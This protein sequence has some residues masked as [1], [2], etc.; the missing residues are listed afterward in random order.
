[1]VLL[2]GCG[3]AAEDYY[4]MPMKPDPAIV[5]DGDLSDWDLVPNPIVLKGREHVTYSPELWD[6]DADLSATVRLCWRTGLLAIAAEV[7]DA[8]LRQPYAGA[9][10]WR[11]DH[12]N[13]WVDFQPGVDPERT[14]FGEG[15]VHLVV[16]PGD[17]GAVKPEIH[18][19]R[20]E[21]RNPG[22]GEAAARRT[23]T[24][25]IVEAVI[26]VERLGVAALSMYKD[27]NFEVALSDADNE[28]V[29]QESLMTRGTEPWVYSRKRVLPMVF[30]DG[31][32]KAPPPLR[33]TLLKDHAEIAAGQTLTLPFDSGAIPEGKEA[34]VFLRARYPQEKVTGFRAEALH[35]DLNGKRVGVDR[36]ANRA[37]RMTLMRGTDE[38]MVSAD[39][40][41]ALYYAPDYFPSPERHALYG[42]IDGSNPTEYEFRLDGVLR[43]GS[44]TLTVSN[45][46][47]VTPEHAHTAH[48]DSVEFR[49]RSK[50]APP[51]P[52][53]PAPTG[54]IPWIAPATTFPKSY[55]ATPQPGARIELT[56]AGE[57]LV[58]ESRFS[59]PD[60]GWQT[61]SNRF[62]RHERQVSEH[63][64]WLEVS[65]TFT[66]LTTENL[67]LIQEHRCDL[68]KRFRAAWLAGLEMPAGNGNRSEG[69][70]PSAY[71]TTE[72]L[73][74]G[75]FA[76]NDAFIV[77]VNQAAQN[78]VLSLS[79]REF[80]LQPGA[81][82][83]ATLAVVPTTRPDFWQFVNAARRAREV[84]FP[85]RWSFAFMY[86]EWPVYEWT[87]DTVRRF[88]DNKGANFVV[89]SNDVRNQRGQYARATDWLNADL[90][91]Y[92]DFQKRIRSL[93]PDGSVNTGI[94]YHCFLDTTRE[95]DEAYKADRGRDAAGNY[96][97]YGGEGAYM[98]T[99]IPTL[100]PGHWGGVME[101]VMSTILDDIRA[102]GVFWDEFVYSRVPYV[103][104]QQDGVSADID[105]ETHRLL[106]TKGS[107]TLVSL[108]FRVK[109]VD[110]ILGEKRPFLINGAPHT[111]TMVDKHFM[112]F[113]ETGSMSNCRDMLLH[114]PVALGDHL[115][116]RK[117]ADS[118][119]NLHAALQHGCLFVWYTHIFHNHE[120]PTKYFYPFT[121]IELHPGYVIGKERIVTAVSGYFG[122]GD[123][124]EYEAHCFDRDGKPTDAIRVPRV[125]RDG[126]AYAEVRLPEGCL[127]ILVRVQK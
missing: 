67:P 4:V 87:D 60:G 6:G 2:A 71:A 34:F 121:P 95:N 85:L 89:Q 32:G 19:Y 13:L 107:M 109:M 50:V 94:Y 43:E 24:G 103:Y 72:T 59:T 91:L 3:R 54:E 7:T 55:A 5:A 126:K 115:T 77:H 79:D 74:I 84:N 22:P 65:D 14:M 106:R 58:L 69:D 44:N 102:N 75:L 56:V 52:P 98:H 63:D 40:A 57:P 125:L 37:A 110:R 30:G 39:G 16:S 108:P 12:I 17:F 119:A 8:N 53:K 35:L 41:L 66:N 117:Y 127:A 23:A 38:T 120:A 68:G 33:G 116:E 9:D 64:E 46:G 123:A 122:W 100:E 25:Y 88:I 61:G 73:G 78:G 80:Y 111:R 20:P 112:A 104:G 96:M 1:M 86:H 51:P 29:K 42:T 83:T 21:G 36:L 31:N 105:P 101:K 97:D 114:S 113:T 11:G 18:V 118:Y 82:Y 26:P 62:F 28:P 92:R 45:L 70:N 124:S 76:H 27:A 15:Q 47:T 99:F 49:I 10:I 90:A 48:V 93:Y 81:T